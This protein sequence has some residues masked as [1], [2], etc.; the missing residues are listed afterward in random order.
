MPKCISAPEQADHQHRRGDVEAEEH[1]AQHERQADQDFERADH[2]AAPGGRGGGEPSRCGV[3]RWMSVSASISSSSVCGPKRS[4]SSCVRPAQ[5]QAQRIDRGPAGDQR[6]TSGSRRARSTAGSTSAWPAAWRRWRRR[7]MLSTTTCVAA[8][9]A[10]QRQRG[11]AQHRQ[12]VEQRARLHREARQ[13]E[14]DPR[15]AARD[16]RVGEAEGADD[17]V[18]VGADLVDT[19]QAEAR[20]PCGRASR[21]R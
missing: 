3:F 15:V 16:Q 13:Q 11:Q 10:Q 17:A 4:L 8:P 1:Q 21:C 5:E 19:L 14:V 6:R 12:Q 9:Q 7:S 18:G 2:D 20:T